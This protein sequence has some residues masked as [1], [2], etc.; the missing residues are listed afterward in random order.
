MKD[1]GQIKRAMLITGSVTG[2]L[3]LVSLLALKLY[4]AFFKWLALGMIVF[5]ILFFIFRTLH[6]YN[7]T[8]TIRDKKTEKKKEES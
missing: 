6:N 8:Y 2:F 4:P 1:P 7:E 3:F 5:A